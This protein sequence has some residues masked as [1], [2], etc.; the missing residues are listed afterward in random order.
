MLLNRFQALEL[1]LLVKK[2][3]D[4]KGYLYPISNFTIKNIN[5]FLKN[6]DSLIILL[7]K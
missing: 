4:Y 3:Y 6:W 1:Q 7:Y 5:G 2:F